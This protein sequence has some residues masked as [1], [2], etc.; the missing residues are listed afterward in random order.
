[1]CMCQLMLIP[2]SGV[3]L[4]LVCQKPSAPGK[5]IGLLEASVKCVLELPLPY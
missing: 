1:M 5:G 4:P 3:L 2:F